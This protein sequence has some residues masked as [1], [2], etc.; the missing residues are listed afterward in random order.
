MPASNQQLKFECRQCGR[1]FEVD[2]TAIRC[3]HCKGRYIKPV[4]NK[5]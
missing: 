4:E 2:H 5:R 3:P 1:T